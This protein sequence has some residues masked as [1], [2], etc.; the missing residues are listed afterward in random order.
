MIPH[1][2]TFCRK[3]CNTFLSHI[4]GVPLRPTRKWRNSL[5]VKQFIDHIFSIK[6]RND[7]SSHYRVKS[8]EKL[9]F[10]TWVFSIICPLFPLIMSPTSHKIA[11]ILLLRTAFWR[12]FG[13]VS[14]MRP[15]FM[16]LVVVLESIIKYI[17]VDIGV[18]YIFE[19]HT[20]RCEK[21]VPFNFKYVLFNTSLPGPKF[22]TCF[23]KY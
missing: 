7:G 16:R 1:K 2:T 20:L 3:K 5:H 21:W 14:C 13:A 9:L 8:R 17:W 23:W 10:Y 12:N 11:L 6:F 19:F 4:W 15:F 18:E 22:R